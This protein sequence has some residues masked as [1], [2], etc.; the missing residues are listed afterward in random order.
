MTPAQ[1]IKKWSDSSLRERQGAQEHFIDLCRMLGQPTPAE[2]DPHGDHYCFE[3][4]AEKTGGGDGW[5]DVWRKG[6]F[7][8]EYKGKHK[9]LD[10]ALRQLTT[11]A[12]A[13]E[14]PPYLVV[15]DMERIIVHTSWTNTISRK[16]VFTLD[17]LHEPEKLAVL[18]LVFEGSDSL[19]PKISPQELT[20]TVAQRFGDLGRR[21]QER[22][23]HPRDVAH[24]LNRLVF[25]MFAEDAKLLPEGLFTRM[26]RSMQGRPPAEAGPQFDALFAMMRTGGLFGAD[27]IR[28]F[29]GGLFDDKPALPLE[30]PDIKLI[31]DTADL[32]DWSQL[33]P[34]VFGNMFE[35]ALKATRERAA[36]GAHYTDREKILKI[37][38]PVITWPLT[39]EWEA[40]LVEIRGAMDARAATE[41]E[42]KAVLEAAA[43]AMKADPDKAKAGEAARRKALTAIAKRADAALG[44]AKDRL[45]AFLSRLAA[46]RVLDPACGSGNFLYVALHA[47][48]D[49]ERRA[50]VD[51]ERLG[52][53]VPAP[54]VGLAC[55]RG[56]EIE[57]Y[58]A[59]LARVTLWIGD[60]QWNAR[61]NYTGLAEPILSSLDQI[62][63]R[64]ALLNADGSEAVWPEADAIVGNPPFLGG[65]RL[66]DS[67]GDAYVERLFAAYRGKVP[68]EADFVAYWVE[69]AWRA[70]GDPWDGYQFGGG[71]RAGLVTT[72]SIR[73]GA[74]RRVL[75]PIAEVFALREVWPDEPWVLNGADVR[76]SM[77]GFGWGFPEQRINGQGVD[78]INADLSGSSTDLTKSA[79][80]KENASTAFMGDTKGGSFDIPGDLA[81]EWLRLPLNPNGRSNSEVLKPWR[82]AMD[83]TRRTADK[84]IID[85]GWTMGEGE[86]ALY[87][88]PFRHA[89]IFVKPERDRNNRETYRINWWRHVEARQGMWRKLNG[90]KRYIAT[91]RVAKHR[92]FSWLETPTVPDSRIFIFASDGDVLF[93]LLHS[94]QHEL[95]SLRTASWHGVGNDPTYNTE[96]CFETFPFPEGLTPNIPAAD[97]AADPRAIAI[98]DAAAEL[99]RL[100]EAWLNPADLVRTEPEV[101]PGY[102][103]RVLPVSP[104]A[105]LELKKRTLTNL[106][107]QRPQWLAMAHQRLDAAV[108]AAYGWP[109]GLSDD[110][111]LERLFALNQERAAAGR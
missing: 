40:A 28:W 50:L 17:D 37:I 107:N 69:K 7:G 45:E 109:N 81:R 108:A 29:N 14:N 80:L 10:A 93:G 62:E 103:D 97:Y 91:P 75:A 48:K 42:R 9:N 43:D 63:C 6:C 18:R 78:Q 95:W 8:W 4:G 111:V 71:K 106:Y 25:C 3:R 12:Q 20:A 31:C 87:E 58:A 83:V 68:A 41:V 104:E 11:Y 35:E 94:K 67:L 34:S 57:D 44:L 64:D 53:E 33:D 73:G 89:L 2:D 88:T 110:E 72:N 61:N 32:H 85:F 13:L 21:L 96:S 74:N 26:T 86:A 19:K 24:F 49:I 92:T 16:I 27:I 76:V 99:N 100:R 56:L 54:R 15:C 102:P 65:K 46:Y 23:H 59:E 36:L 77:F 70:V 101:V 30:R 55:V 39:A 84:W 98:G 52:I 105:A 66:R 5:A 82:N 60:L 51:A 22:G 79:R 1:F 90:L 47:L 38:D